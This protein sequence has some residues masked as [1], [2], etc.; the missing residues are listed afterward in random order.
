MRYNQENVQDFDK[1]IIHIMA[2]RSNIRDVV[3]RVN[4]ISTQ[5]RQQEKLIA[6]VGNNDTVF[7]ERLALECRRSTK[8]TKVIERPKKTEQGQ[9]ANSI[10]RIAADKPVVTEKKKRR[11]VEGIEMMVVLPDSFLTWDISIQIKTLNELKDYVEGITGTECLIGLHDSH[12]SEEAKGKKGNC[13]VHILMAERPLLPEK[14]IKIATRNIFINEEGKH[15]S[16]RTDILD[17]LD[18]LRPGCQVFSKGET[19]PNGIIALKTTYIDENGKERRNKAD[20]YNMGQIRPGCYVIPKG[21]VISMFDSKYNDMTSNYWRDRFKQQMA[22]WI[23]QTFEPDLKRVVYS[24]N[25]PYIPY[26]HVG[27]KLSAEVAEDIDFVNGYIKQWNDAIRTGEF[28]YYEDAMFYKSLIML[29]PN[30][31]GE[32][33]NAFHAISHNAWPDDP[34]YNY[35]DR[36]AEVPRSKPLTKR[37]RMNEEL[38]ECYRLAQVERNLANEADDFYEKREHE[39]KAKHYSAEIDRLNRALGYWKPERYFQ[40]M[41]KD[42]KELAKLQAEIEKTKYWIKVYAKKGDEVSVR[43]WRANKKNL[44]ELK[45]ASRALSRQIKQNKDKWK[46]SGYE[47]GGLKEM[48]F[49]ERIR[50]AEARSSAK[51]NAFRDYSRPHEMT[52]G[53]TLTRA[54]VMLDALQ[55]RREEDV[56]SQYELKERIKSAGNSLVRLKTAVE[57]SESVL[58]GYEDVKQLI[59]EY[60]E[61]RFVQNFLNMPEGPEKRKELSDP[62]RKNQI[63]RY[64]ALQ[65]KLILKGLFSDKEIEAFK[66]KYNRV[67]ND[68]AKSK[69]LMEAKE[70][71]YLRLRKVQYANYLMAGG[72][73]TDEYEKINYSKL[74]SDYEVKIDYE[75]T[76]AP[77]EHD[78]W[79]FGR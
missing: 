62:Y 26:I 44:Q 29:A 77:P 49:D 59:I 74:R 40:E 32:I 17:K 36:T 27:K 53:P 68:M 73:E 58:Q 20:V 61:I 71:E 42:E 1:D 16:R 4:Y 60:Q 57:T 5:E 67:L 46:A 31:A 38:R 65:D 45:L 63:A 3:D 64:Y 8:N 51:Q 9:G 50:S 33:Y 13:H 2:Q 75:H 39:S 11:A 78:E 28:I 23:N 70:Q 30:K 34:E 72:I 21:E 37:E 18:E 54:Q 52:L 19:L 76:E 56:S 48:S 66:R 22:D 47:L 41:R 25:S 79:E 43:K 55:I 24:E 12:R 15:V 7:W 10:T 14:E 35:E 69:E 6:Y